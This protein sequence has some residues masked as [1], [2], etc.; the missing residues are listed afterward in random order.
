[1]RLSSI[2]CGVTALSL[3]ASCSTSIALPSSEVLKNAAAVGR[4]LRSVEFIGTVLFDSTSAQPDKSSGS[5]SINGRMQD[6]GSQTQLSSTFHILSGMPATSFDGEAELI[7]AAPT[8]VYVLLKRLDTEPPHPLFGSPLVSLLY[9]HWWKLPSETGSVQQSVTPDP[10]LLRMQTDAI[11]VVE[12]KG[13]EQIDGAESYHYNVKLNREKLA[14]FLK[15]VGAEEA[16]SPEALDAFLETSD[17]TGE[18]WIDAS[19]FALRKLEWHIRPKEGEGNTMD[20]SVTFSN[21]NAA[22]PIV[23]PEGATDLPDVPLPGMM[24]EVPS[25][26]LEQPTDLPADQQQLLQSLMQ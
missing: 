13:F 1:M 20:I 25:G 18:V 7:V 10:K 2:F 4:E 16:A 15:E 19:T 8:E 24:Q 17:A 23:P 14:Q 3:L 22:Q 5:I 12:E 26:L 6:G 11:E 21:H 9:N